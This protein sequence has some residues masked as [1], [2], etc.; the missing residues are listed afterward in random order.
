MRRAI[1]ISLSAIFL[2]LA[3]ILVTNRI[4]SNRDRLVTPT[5]YPIPSLFSTEADKDFIS[6]LVNDTDLNSG[7]AM[8]RVMSFYPNQAN[9]I[10]FAV[11]NHTD[12]PILFP[13][14][15]FGLTVF[16]YNDLNHLWE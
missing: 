4:S 5:S 12:E 1:P 3:F 14:Q 11:F 9:N 7:I 15:G 10:T 6:S 16:R 13:D 2:I 8:E